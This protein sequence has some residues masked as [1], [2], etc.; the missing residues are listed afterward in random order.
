MSGLLQGRPR[1]QRG[2]AL[3]HRALWQGFKSLSEQQVGRDKL[4]VHPKLLQ[5]LTQD[6]NTFSPYSAKTSQQES[7]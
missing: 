6:T 2:S 3:P 1:H 4:C 7:S 5:L